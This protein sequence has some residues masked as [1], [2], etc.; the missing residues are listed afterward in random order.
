MRPLRENIRSSSITILLQLPTLYK[1]QGLRWAPLNSTQYD[2]HEISPLQILRVARHV[3]LGG[4]SVDFVPI[5]LRIAQTT[6]RLELTGNAS[7]FTN[8]QD[9]ILLKRRV[10]AREPNV[11]IL[12]WI[13][14]SRLVLLWQPS[15]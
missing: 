4:L 8:L 6:E 2:L 13:H 11:C 12:N 9:P 3:Y 5:A 10:R 15:R 7:R 14:T 1:F